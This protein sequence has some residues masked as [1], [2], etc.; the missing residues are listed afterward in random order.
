M[1]AVSSDKSRWRLRKAPLVY[2]LGQVV[3]SPVLQM[4][5]YI[6]K[7]QEELR[8]RGY[9]RF[10]ENQIQDVIF[11]PQPQARVSSRWIFLS[12]NNQESVIISNE[13][14]ALETSAYDT[15]EKFVEEL[16]NVV[17]IVHRIVKIALVERIGLRYV[18][19]IQPNQNEAFDDYIYS[20]LLGLPENGTGINRLISQYELRDQSDSGGQLI[21]RFI[22]T[23]GVGFLPPDL[24]ASHLSFKPEFQSN[25]GVTKGIL[26]ID[27]L[28]M[29]QVDFNSSELSKTMWELHKWTKQA[30]ETAITDEALKRWGKEDIKLN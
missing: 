27:H 5:E 18:N 14:I 16:I 20:G 21:V 15:F 8:K 29:S 22:Q 12:T 9:P 13:F 23:K 4:K 2:V 17:E 28:L 26:D 7:I 6:P 1:G 3:I 10:Q 24:E 19:L 30:F 25:S 11:G